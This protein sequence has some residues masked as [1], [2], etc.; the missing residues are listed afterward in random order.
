M[1]AAY[2]RDRIE[3]L[4]Q[5]VVGRARLR[6]PDHPEPDRG[7]HR[8]PRR[9]SA[10]WKAGRS[11]S[12]FPTRTA[13]SSTPSSARSSGCS[14]RWRCCSRFVL[15]LWRGA[16]R[17]LAA[18]PTPSARFLAA[19]LTLAIVLQALINVS[20][21][22]GLLPTKGIPLPFIS[23]GGSSLVFTLLRRR[24][25]P[26]HL[27][28]CGLTWHAPSSIAAGGTGGH[29]FPGIAVADELVRARRRDARRLRRH[30]ARPRVAARA[31]GRLR[32]RA[33]AHPSAQRRRARC[34]RSKGCSPCRGRCVRA[35]ALVRRLT[36]GAPCS[37][38]AA[39]RAGRSCSSP[40]LLGIRT[41][42]LEPNAKPGFTN[43]VL[44]PFVR[45]RGLLR[46]RRRAREFGAQGRGHRQPRARRLRAR[47]PQK[48]HR[49]PLTLLVVRRQPGLAHHQPARWS[50]RCR[51]CRAP[52]ACASCTR[53]GPAMRDE[54]AAAYAGGR[55]RGGGGGVPRRHGAALRATPT[56]CVCAQRRHHLRGADGGGQ[57]RA[58]SSPSRGRPTTTRRATRAPWRPRARRA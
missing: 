13:T 30:A 50:P 44:R 37:G 57:G 7:G 56:S 20:V 29:L 16:A 6:L 21:V 1:S 24:A 36:A 5:P 27:P 22:L 25:H 40:P 48:P 45:R 35:V 15:L 42:I 53:P 23:A 49:P 51:T 3:A 32:A 26:E 46:T 39:T 11:S 54:V 14:A 2:R 47:C 9:A 4:P 55:P 43:R 34:A 31:A 33:A 58:C 17:G 10:S 12:T 38:S 52:T 19:G 28:A 8:R 18:R 41:V